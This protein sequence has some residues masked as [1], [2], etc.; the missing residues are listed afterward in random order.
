[1]MTKRTSLPEKIRTHKFGRS[2]AM[3]WSHGTASDTAAKVASVTSMLGI[4]R[5]ATHARSVIT[6][7]AIEYRSLSRLASAE[8]SSNAAGRA[9]GAMPKLLTAP[10]LEQHEQ[11]DSQDVAQGTD[12]TASPYVNVAD[13]HA[14]CTAQRFTPTME[15]YREPPQS[16]DCQD[17]CESQLC[18]CRRRGGGCSHACSCDHGRHPVRN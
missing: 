14:P 16:C 15:W 11:I 7:L 5:L 9:E 4:V 3:P 1:M 13:V 2:V 8:P 10:N 6:W 17:D 12:R 18:S